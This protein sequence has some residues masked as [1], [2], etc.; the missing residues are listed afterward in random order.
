MIAAHLRDK[1][2]LAQKVIDDKRLKVPVFHAKKPFRKPTSWPMV[3]VFGADGTELYA[4]KS[5]DD[6]ED[7]VRDARSAKSKVSPLDSFR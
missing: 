7:A 4:G 5:H 2:S 3:Y 1:I 6:A